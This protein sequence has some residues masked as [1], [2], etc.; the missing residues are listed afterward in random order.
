MCSSVLLLGL[1]LAGAPLSGAVEAAAPADTSLQ[2]ALDNWSRLRARQRERDAHLARRGE[3]DTITVGSLRLLVLPEAA[4]AARSAAREA[5]ELLARRYG[6]ATGV[7]A[8]MAIRVM[9]EPG[10]RWQVVLL[11]QGGGTSRGGIQGRGE[12]VRALASLGERGIWVTTDTAL[13]A[14]LPPAPLETEEAEL[15][16]RAYY[17]LALSSSTVAR[18]CLVGDLGACEEALRL[19]PGPDP[20]TRWYDAAGRRA[21]VTRARRGWNWG[22]VQMELLGCLEDGDDAACTTLLRRATRLE[23]RTP[24]EALV[25]GQ[26]R[27]TIPPPLGEYARLLLLEAAL[28]QGG[29]GAWYRLASATP[30]PL[31][32]RMAAAANVAA[33]SLLGLWRAEVEAA[34]PTPAAV[35]PVLVVGTALWAG[36]LATLSCRV[37]R[38]R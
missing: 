13:R 19:V 32:A 7:L 3:E 24:A 12:L 10:D 25:W 27:L 6:D 20:L 23:G 21:L 33:D 28:R 29:E 2:A 11:A 22:P 38:W 17:E 8:A 35:P 36:L 30:G 31:S 37:L 26:D 34:R 4:A 1:L 9:A 18:G 5:H 16:R 15:A 14:W